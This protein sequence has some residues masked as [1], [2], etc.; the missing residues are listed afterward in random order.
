MTAGKI[1]PSIM[2]TDFKNECGGKQYG[3]RKRLSLEDGLF[4]M[5]RGKFFLLHLKIAAGPKCFLILLRIIY[6]RSIK[7]L[8]GREV[9]P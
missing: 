1:K 5:R 6:D 4:F 7:V 2:G 8:F 9:S 3:E